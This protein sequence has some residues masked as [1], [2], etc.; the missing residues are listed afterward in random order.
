[1]PCCPLNFAGRNI[2][3]MACCL[4]LAIAD[5]PSHLTDAR[6]TRGFSSTER[7]ISSKGRGAGVW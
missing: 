5:P 1:M 7:V 3:D 2:L 6:S 4:G